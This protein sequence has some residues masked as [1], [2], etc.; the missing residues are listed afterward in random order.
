MLNSSNPQT[1]ALKTAK[2]AIV[3]VNLFGSFFPKIPVTAKPT[4]GKEMSVNK[5]IF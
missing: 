5:S 3:T 2:V 4:K 1:N